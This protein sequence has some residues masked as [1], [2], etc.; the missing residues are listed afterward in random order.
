MYNFI[1]ILHSIVRWLVVIAALAAVIRAFA[2][3]F[4]RLAWDRLDDRL[5]FFF[6]LAMDVQALIGILLYI[7]SPLIH[8]ALANFGAALKD[9][10]T[11]FFTL[12][13]W[14]LVLVAVA[15]AH[16]GRSLARKAHEDGRK[17]RTAALFFGLSIL[18]LLI[19]IPWPFDFGRPWIRL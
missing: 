8:Q 7:F 10:T 17:F 14:L 4:G 16:M 9:G 5:G 15:L 13:H 1:L 19:A 2:G 3:W 11:L 12:F 6:T 18:V